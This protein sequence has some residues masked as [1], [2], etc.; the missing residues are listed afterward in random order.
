M[1]RITFLT[2][3]LALAITISTIMIAQA[4][5]LMGGKRGHDRLYGIRALMQLY[6]SQDQKQAIYDIYLKYHDAQKAT[7][8]SLKE[9]KEEFFIIASDANFNEDNIR[10]AFRESVPAMEE[11]AVL[12]VRIGSEIKAVLTAGQFEELQQIKAKHSSRGQKKGNNEFRRAMLETWLIMDS[13]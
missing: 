1:K 9:Q 6:L 8:S 3:V 13:E 7:R 12:R 10:Q 11:A 5:P 2:T 4:E